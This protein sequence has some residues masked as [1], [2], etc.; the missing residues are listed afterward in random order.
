MNENRL[1]IIS[2]G[3]D[4]PRPT[5]LSRK[6]RT[7]ELQA[8]FERLWLLD[9]EKFNPNRN[10]IERERIERTWEFITNYLDI[11]NSQAA[12]IGCGSGIF[13]R[14]LR[15]RG[16]KVD[17]IDIAENALKKFKELGSDHIHLKQD[18]MPETSLPDQY[19]DIIVCTELVAELPKEEFRLFFAELSR[20]LKPTGYLIC[21]SSIDIDTEGGI[22]KLLE[23]AQTEFDIL[24]GRESYHSLS[25]KLKR[26]LEAPSLFIQSWKNREKRAQ[27]LSCKK[28]FNKGWFWLNT[29]PLL[30]WPW[31]I[32]ELFARPLLRFLKNNRRL[33]L[34]LERLSRF[35]S[36]RNGISH[37]LFLA[38][39]RPIQMVDPKDMPIQKLGR[40][41]IWE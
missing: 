27:E 2:S 25:I 3:S 39:Q 41:E 7:K 31:Y 34:I 8:K 22:E 14:L 16:A 10:C 21:S 6:A 35:I 23:L 32:L 15:D 11:V 36:D 28:G 13:S 5:P 4:I 24:A 26:F 17:A 30:I 20:L 19:Y 38:K 1:N 12:D 18:A 29:T 37:Y 9:P 33:M 40:K